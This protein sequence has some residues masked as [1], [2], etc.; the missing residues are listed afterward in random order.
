MMVGW[1]AQ[2]GPDQ[3]VSIDGFRRSYDVV[4]Q[5]EHLDFRSA[6][7]G[8]VLGPQQYR[9]VL[10]YQRHRNQR[11]EKPVAHAIQ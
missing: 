9:F 6:G 10:A 4:N 8:E 11:Q 2:Q 1:I 7:C 5:R 3:V